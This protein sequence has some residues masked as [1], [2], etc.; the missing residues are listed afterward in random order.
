MS[1]PEGGGGSCAGAAPGWWASSGHWA[2]RAGLEPEVGFQG[3]RLDSLFMRVSHLPEDQVLL[4]LALRA[5]DVSFSPSAQPWPLP[6]SSPFSALTHLTILCL[7]CH[8]PRPISPFPSSQIIPNI[9]LLP[10]LPP[11]TPSIFLKATIF[12][13]HHA[14]YGGCTLNKTDKGSATKGKQTRSSRRRG[15]VV[16][17][18]D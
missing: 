11:F 9:P 2:G 13:G 14:R 6:C 15:A 17:E 8:L 18:S 16:D 7:L 1:H 10:H 12:E 3:R 4:T 5:G